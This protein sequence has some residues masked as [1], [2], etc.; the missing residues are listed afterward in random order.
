VSDDPTSLALERIRKIVDE[1]RRRA[2]D[3]R[4][5]PLRHWSEVQRED[6]RDAERDEPE[7]GRAGG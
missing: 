5:A 1:A 7:R 3:D 6:E 2:P 4:P